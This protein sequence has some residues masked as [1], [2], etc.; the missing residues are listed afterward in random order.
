MTSR[1]MLT[2]IQHQIRILEDVTDN[3]NMK[4]LVAEMKEAAEKLEEMLP[5]KFV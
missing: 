3:D 5:E 2:M 1:E 4:I